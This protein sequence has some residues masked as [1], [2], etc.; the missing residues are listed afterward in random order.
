MR[1]MFYLILLLFLGQ[2]VYCQ[3]YRFT[4]Q[5]SSSSIG[6]HAANYNWEL[7]ND[8]N[9]IDSFEKGGNAISISDKREFSDIYISSG[10]TLAL[11]SDCQNNSICEFNSTSSKTL[12]QLINAIY[13]SLSGCNGNVRLIDFKPNVTISNLELNSPSEICA[14]SLLQLGA[15]PAGFPSSVYH[16]QYSTNNQINWI[17]LPLNINGKNTNNVALTEITMHELLGINHLNYLNQT[18]FFRLGYNQTNN[19]TSP[20]SIKYYPCA[21]IL[22]DRTY[23]APDCKGGPIK[24]ITAYFQ[25]PLEPNETLSP[26]QII[27]Y[28][29]VNGD[30]PFFSQQE[31]ITSIEFDNTKNLWAYKFKNLNSGR[32][33][34]NKRYIIEYQAKKNGVPRGT[35]QLFE[36][37]I[38]NDPTAVEFEIIKAENPSCHNGT[39]EIVISLTG[40]TGAYKFY[41]D[42]IEIISAARKGTDGFYHL[43]N[44]APKEYKIKVVD[45]KGCIDENKYD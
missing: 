23:E 24:E 32:L 38:Y 31:E 20:L 16:W 18:I 15:F 28:P 3:T 12:N 34:N 39:V 17:D 45:G 9:L 26:M 5:Y 19:F 41:D 33:I 11:I 29:K 10:I 25:R 27:P 22:V 43:K 13:P 40:G 14:G 44:L 2:I 30:S 37:F 1:R 7:Y 36:P 35:L 8:S 6:C 21:P 4:I 42:T